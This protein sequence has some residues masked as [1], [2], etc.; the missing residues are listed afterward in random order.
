MWCR[1]SDIAKKGVTLSTLHAVS[2]VLAGYGLVFYRPSSTWEAPNEVSLRRV[3]GKYL[4]RLGRHVIGDLTAEAYAYQGADPKPVSVAVVEGSLMVVD[5]VESAGWRVTA[6]TGL[7]E[8]TPL[9]ADFTL[10]TGDSVIRAGQELVIDDP[11]DYTWR[12][13]DMLAVPPAI[14]RSVAIA[15]GRRVRKLELDEDADWDDMNMNTLIDGFEP[16]IREYQA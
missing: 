8:L 1:A 9:L 6:V 15:V 10:A 12:A 4:V 7:A 13:G 11:M 3:D 14:L 5:E 2:D 16:E